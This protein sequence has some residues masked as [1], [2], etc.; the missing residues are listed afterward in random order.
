MK[1][2]SLETLFELSPMQQGV[3]FHTLYA[4]GSSVYVNQSV[5]ALD[6]AVDVRAMS[7]A[8]GRLIGRHQVLRCSFFWEGIERP[9]QAVHRQVPF[10]IVQ[11]DWRD[12]APVSYT[13]LTLPTSDLV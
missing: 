12:R 9:V 11:H 6:G 5:I 2:A 10:A 1:P 7:S 4:P 13:H 8:W 3:L